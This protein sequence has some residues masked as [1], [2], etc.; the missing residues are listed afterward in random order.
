MH[1][2]LLTTTRV[3]FAI[4]FIVLI[5]ALRHSSLSYLMTLETFTKKQ[6]ALVQLVHNHYGAAVLFYIMLYIIIVAL[7][8]PFSA[9]C[10]MVGGFLFGVIPAVFYTNIGATIGAT[11]FFL[12]IRFLLGNTLQERYKDKLKIFNEQMDR[13]GIFYLIAIHFIAVIP[14]F[15]VNI[16]I[17]MT[18]VSVWTFIWTT[19]IGILPSSFVYA[20]AGR[21]LGTLTHIRDIFS[22]PIFIAFGLLTILALIPIFIHWYSQS[23]E[24]KL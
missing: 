1:R 20:F 21:Q 8:M 9:L 5:I 7:A 11:F 23:K 14:F 6:L 24:K 17:S 22:L 19:S 13:Y 2:R 12:I 16:L 18:R 4:I 3:W 15:V 10:T